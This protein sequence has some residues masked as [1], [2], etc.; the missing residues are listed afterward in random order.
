MNSIIKNISLICSCIAGLML[1][2]SCSD[3]L[4]EKQN[5]TY[6]DGSKLS[7]LQAILDDATYMNKRSTSLPEAASDDYFLPEN[8]YNKL[9]Q[10]GKEAYRWELRNYTFSNDW[11]N[12]YLQ[13]YNANL[14]LE[15]LSKI[16]NEKSDI[17]IRNRIYGSAH[18]YRG[19]A[20]LAL[21]TT[22]CKAYRE[23][24]ASSDLGIV[25]RDV[26]DF[27]VNTPRSSLKAS[28]QKII[29]DLNIAKDYLS[30]RVEIP[31]RP[32]K[33]AAYA[34]LS[35]TYLSMRN[36]HQAELY[37]DSALMLHS[38]VMDFNDPNLKL[39]SNLPFANKYNPEVVFYSAIGTY[40][41]S[42]AHPMYA[43][44][45][46]GLYDSYEVADLRKQAYFLPLADGY[47][48]KGMY[49]ENKNLCFTGIT[50]AELLLIKA[51][52]RAR[53][54][55]VKGTT[56]AMKLILQKRYNNGVYNLP[57][58]LNQE[59]VLAW[60]LLERRK[61]LLMRGIRY[62]DLKRLNAEGAEI[63]LSRFVD[64]VAYSLLPNDARYAQPLPADAVELGGLKQN[65]Y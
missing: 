60:V 57:Q 28:Y 3:F 61:E 41:I 24:E 30:D 13:V 32:S 37:A 29:E 12:L 21:V 42:T 47:R 59:N 39:G 23:E 27:N 18:F 20:Y 11:A 50:T 22:F 48:F 52:C 10:K 62:S 46:K 33:A 51:E 17:D 25:L 16:V 63:K 38:E 56:D 43:R 2:V 58:E 49:S 9:T 1:T 7:D 19:Y 44:I 14:C 8:N 36:Y 54:K 53:E 5:F 45:D 65:P 35:R 31:L 6:S 26:S 15:G 4:N 34:A 40:S 55:D 64:G